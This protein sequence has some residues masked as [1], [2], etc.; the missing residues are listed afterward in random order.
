[1]V[2]LPAVDGPTDNPAFP[3]APDD[4]AQAPGPVEAAPSGSI[5]SE[6]VPTAAE[7]DAPS[8]GLIRFGIALALSVLALW[9][10]ALLAPFL[11]AHAPLLPMVFAVVLSAWWAGAG[12]GVFSTLLCGFIGGFLFVDREEAARQAWSP[13]TVALLIFL[14]QGIFI[15][16]VIGSRKRTEEPSTDSPAAGEGMGKV[17]E[18]GE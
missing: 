1:M 16:V 9:G 18:R 5:A 11:G 14:V 6:A 13:Q 15:S 4:R 10:R 7:A 17:V 8:S 2:W 12:P 3:P